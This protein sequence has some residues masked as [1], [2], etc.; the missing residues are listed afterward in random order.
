MSE[1]KPVIVLTPYRSTVPLVQPLMQAGFEVWVP[2]IQAAQQMPGTFALQQLIDGPMHM[3][4][5]SE[6]ALLDA[7]VVAGLISQTIYQRMEKE[8]DALTPSHNEKDDKDVK[9][10]VLAGLQQWFPGWVQ[11]SMARQILWL[12]VMERLCTEREVR[13]VVMQNDIEEITKTLCLF[14]AG[15][16]IPSVHVPHAVYLDWGHGEIG[17]DVHDVVSADWVCVAGWFQAEWYKARGARRIDTTGL[18]QWDIHVELK[19]A[20]DREAACRQF[21]LNT[22]KPVVVYYSSWRQETAAQGFHDGIEV[23]YKSLLQAAKGADWQLL[24]KTHPS[25]QV[26][27]AEWHAKL[28]D[29]MKVSCLVTDNHLNATYQVADLVFAFGTS[30]TIV[31][32]AIYGIP[33]ASIFGFEADEAVITCGDAQKS[34]TGAIEQALSDDWQ[35]WYAGQNEAFLKKYAGDVDGLATERVAE[36]IVRLAG[37]GKV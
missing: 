4:A 21:K 22:D 1:N 36:R 31:E 35:K 3:A 20:R 30:N 14:A 23:A 24:V 5:L 13:A 10:F 19:K 25:A 12:K 8:L 37:K 33:L 9:P 27:N 15:H 28:A 11:Q 26:E 6:A 32:A 17:Y 16:G 29:E 7:K 18:P 34:I 2:D